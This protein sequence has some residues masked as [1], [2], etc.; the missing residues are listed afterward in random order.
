M[1]KEKDEMPPEPG[2]EKSGPKSNADAEGMKPIKSASRGIKVMALKVGIYK[3][4]RMEPG[5]VFFI[6]KKE[7]LGSWMKCE[8]QGLQKEHSEKMKARKAALR[9]RQSQAGE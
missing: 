9:N 6:E 3:N 5:K 1:S 2:S 7:H 8:D 4:C